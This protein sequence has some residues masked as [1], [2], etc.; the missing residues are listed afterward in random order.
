MKLNFISKSLKNKLIFSHTIT[1]V[2]VVMF[3]AIIIYFISVSMQI[4]D[5]RNFDE[6]IVEQISGSLKDMIVSFKRINNYV[7]MNK[8]LQR[9]LKEDYT[10]EPDQQRKYELD[11]MLQSIAVEQTLSVNEINSLYLYDTKN[12]RVYFKRHYESGESEKFYSNADP[13]RFTSDGSI[14][15]LVKDGVVSFN[16]VIRD[17]N[18]LEPIGYLTVVMDKNYIQQKINALRSNPNRFLIVTDENGEVIVHNYNNEDK[19]QDILNS[20]KGS[21]SHTSRLQNIDTIGLSI[22]TS[23]T[24][25]YSGWKTISVISLGELAKG[26]AVIAEWIFI[27]GFLGVAI[28]IFIS[29]FSSTKLVKPIKALIHMTGEIENENFD[30]RVRASGQDELGKLGRSFNKMVNRIDNLIKEVY[31]EELKLKEAE[32]KALQAQIN[33]HFLYNT[34]DCIN[35]L[36]EFGRIDDIRSVTIALAN[37]M[38]V[39]ANNRNKTIKIKDELDYINA[40][41]LIY[42][43][44]LQDKLNYYLDI[45]EDILEYYIPKLILQPLVENAIIHGLKQKLGQGNV[46]IRGF[47]KDN[48]LVF[49]VFDDGVGMS[50]EEIERYIHGNPQLDEPEITNKQGTKS[51]LRNVIDRVRLIYGRDCG[52]HIESQRDV[53]TMIELK[54]QVKESEE[55]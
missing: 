17:L 19:L 4:A 26:P 37:L 7:S 50:E 11:N 54:I 53:G 9:L 30:V 20:I 32:I 31:Q 49:Q 55:N 51:G 33:P 42:K 24:S 43:V 15:V 46:H 8:D 16:R 23:S 45:E 1:V 21:D 48:Y 25:S 38:K 39:S 52:L 2:I 41:L 14:K 3:I 6:Q 34:L 35:W 47:R 10:L 29:L 18:T 13:E 40:Y 28:G 44:S 36:A 5:A 12:L 27:I 22:I